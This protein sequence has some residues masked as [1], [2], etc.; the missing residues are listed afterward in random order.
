MCVWIGSAIGVFGHNPL[1]P[2]LLLEYMANTCSGASSYSI[3]VRT[4]LHLIAT[5]C[6]Y[7]PL[8]YISTYRR[9]V[10]SKTYVFHSYVITASSQHNFTYL[11]MMWCSAVLFDLQV[12]PRGVATAGRF[13]HHVPGL[14]KQELADRVDRQAQVRVPST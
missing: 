7:M 10:V 4:K 13:W 5:I 9:P 11:H 14:D 8:K 3:C 1:N 2:L 12:W 6:S